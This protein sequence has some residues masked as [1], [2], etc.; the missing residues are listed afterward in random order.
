MHEVVLHKKKLCH[1]KRCR[2]YH[3]AMSTE[4]NIEKVSIYKN[5]LQL[6][7]DL[8][9]SFRSFFPLICQ[10]AFTVRNIFTPRHLAFR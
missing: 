4:A 1:T 3:F 7:S 9:V 6:K 10:L 2:T 5:F 8:S